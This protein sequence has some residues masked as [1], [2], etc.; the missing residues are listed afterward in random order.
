MTDDVTGQG[1]VREYKKINTSNLSL[2]EYFHGSCSMDL[3]D[4]LNF[5]QK[6]THISSC[7]YRDYDRQW[8]KKYRGASNVISY[9]RL[10]DNYPVTYWLSP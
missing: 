2:R 10:Y 4:I 6:S 3:A 7:Y 8:T 1:Y 9:T 5:E